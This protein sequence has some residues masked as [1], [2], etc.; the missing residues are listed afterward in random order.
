MKRL[1]YLPINLIA[2]FALA[3]CISCERDGYETII[4][5][6][7][8]YVEP[9]ENIVPKS[10]INKIDNLYLG[11][12]P[13]IINKR[14]FIVDP[15]VLTYSSSPHDSIGYDWG[16]KL[17]KFYGQ[18]HDNTI[19]YE[20]IKGGTSVKCRAYIQGSGDNF[21]VYFNEDKI[22]PS[23]GS[24]TKTTAIITGTITDEGIN[25]YTYSYIMVN[26]DGSSVEKDFIRK[27]KD[28]DEL[29]KNYN[30]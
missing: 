7:K 5:P 19:T 9:I 18:T 20:S 30:W 24:N 15:Y 3:F 22:S 1:K 2:I 16:H 13:P 28:K 8:R 11:D 25:Y 6:S 10:L 21:T 14:G 12:D 17:I 27:F 29:A 26:P 23:T 4:L